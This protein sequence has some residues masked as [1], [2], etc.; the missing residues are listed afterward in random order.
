MIFEA[1]K[2]VAIIIC[3]SLIGLLVMCQSRPIEEK[4]ADIQQPNFL[5][6]IADDQS[7]PHASIY[8]DQTA[9]T[10]VFD[11]IA[12][13]GVLFLNAFCAAPQ[14]SPNRAAIL[15]GKNIWQLEEAGTHA[16]YF[17]AKF[18]VFTDVLERGGYSLGYT[19]KGWGPGNWKDSGRSRNPVGPEYN[20]LKLD[21][22]P[23]TAISKTDYAGNFRTFLNNRPEGKPFFFWFGSF[24]PHRDYEKGSGTVSGRNPERVYVPPFLPNVREVRSDLLDYA[25]EIEWFDQQLGQMIDMLKEAGLYENTVI[26]I[27]SDNG[28]PYPYAKANL[29][30]YGIHVPLTIAGPSVVQGKTTGALVSSIDIAPTILELA[31]IRENMTF[32]G[33]SLIRILSVQDQGSGNPDI[34]WVLSG[35][36]RH[37]H[38]RPDNLGYPSRSVRNADFLYIHNF[39][40][41]RWPAGDPE[42]TEPVPENNQVVESLKPAYFDIDDGP[43]KEFI[44][45]H[46]KQYP[47]YFRLG[48]DRRPGEELYDIRIDPGC[49]RNLADSARYQGIR[50]ELKALLFQQL[51]EQGDPRLTGKGDIFESYPRIS[52]MRNFP[53]FKE[54]GQYNPAFQNL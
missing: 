22:I 34:Q 49:L 4:P 47:E 18:T 36:E 54:Q 20:E 51:R 11:A 21:S 37:T 53:G 15:T 16:S 25:L 48:F 44:L 10:P 2:I 30:E 27:T 23:T 8:G 5:F 40:P 13:E 6:A 14:C 26:I 19:G 43:V 33:R 17:P 39:R 31:G 9:Q 45:Q 3:C 50:N 42:M 12:R 29:Q 41:E 1:H 35:R 28:M 52:P 24:E 38:A 32:T 7:F 46:K